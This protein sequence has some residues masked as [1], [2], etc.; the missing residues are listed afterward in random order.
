MHHVDALIRWSSLFIMIYR[1]PLPRRV[2][3]ALNHDLIAA[4]PINDAIR[5][6]RD[7][8]L[9]RPFHVAYPTTLWENCQAIGRGTNACEN[10]IGACW[11]APGDKGV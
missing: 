9:A 10:T 7:N 2:Q 3:H 6:T 8:Q 4:H 1:R 5:Q 11:A